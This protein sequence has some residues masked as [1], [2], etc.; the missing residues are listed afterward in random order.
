M[1]S[2][3]ECCEKIEISGGDWF[4]LPIEGSFNNPWYSCLRFDSTGTGTYTKVGQDVNGRP[5]YK[6]DKYKGKVEGIDSKGEGSMILSYNDVKQ[7]WFVS[8]NFLFCNNLIFCHIIF[9]LSKPVSNKK[10]VLY[11]R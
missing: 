5:I 10:M 7:E 11:I 4:T 6:N 3:S 1:V 8:I 9:T 2:F